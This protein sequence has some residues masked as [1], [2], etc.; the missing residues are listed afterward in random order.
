M[1]KGGEL[2][3]Y[4]PGLCGLT[5]KNPYF[6]EPLTVDLGIVHCLVESPSEDEDERVHREAHGLVA[7]EIYEVKEGS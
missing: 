2:E 5:I 1:K 4:V 7:D 3:I 6:K